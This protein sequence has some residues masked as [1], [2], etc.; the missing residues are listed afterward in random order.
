MLVGEKVVLRP[1]EMEDVDTLLRWINDREVG[2]H[3][4]PH[5][6]YS[7]AQE[8][9][10]IE[11]V[12]R[13]ES[14]RVLIIQTHEGRPIGVMGLHRIDQVHRQAELGIFIGEKEYWGQGYGTDAIRTLLRFAFDA[15]N[16]H[17]IYLRVNADNVRAQ[18]CYEKCG[19]VREGT[20]REA[21]F[22]DGGW[23]D[24][25]LMAVLADEFRRC[26]STS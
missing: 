25:H 13:S 17:R 12:S 7:R 21:V 18:R 16:F 2:R 1:P 23:R 9:D 10:W 6:P 22:R 14:D 24:Q 26:C 4:M 15:M 8:R 11:R 19:F 3:L 20:L 5:F